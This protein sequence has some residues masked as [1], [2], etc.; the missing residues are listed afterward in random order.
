MAKPQYDVVIAGG[1]LAG[2]LTARE[3]ASRSSVSVLVLEQDHEIGTPEHCGGLVSL[4]GLKKLG[5][6]PSYRS[7]RNAIARAEIRSKS[8]FFEIDAHR[9]GVIAVDRRELD[10]QI[11]FQA[12]N[13]GVEIRTMCSMRSVSAA[14]TFDGRV[15]HDENEGNRG[16]A[17]AVKTTEGSVYCKFFVDATGLSSLIR[18]QR[19]GIL[20]SG[21]Y[22]VYAPWVDSDTV[23]LHFD[24]DRYPGFFAWIIPLG[25]NKAKIGVAGSGINVINTLNSF[26]ESKGASYSIIR[27]VYAPIYVAGPIKHF[28]QGSKFLFVGDAAGQT[29]PTTA[30][31]IL[32]SGMGGLL[33]GRA[34][35]NAIETEDDSSLSQY[36]VEWLSLF[37]SEFRKLLLARRVFERLDNRALDE[38]FSTVSKTALRRISQEGDFDFHSAPLSVI[39]DAKSAAR[40]LRSLL[41][42]ELRKAR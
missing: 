17:F 3:L 16:H 28:I 22:E 13:L 15:K 35:S 7:Y 2:L 20:P 34:V 19:N 24:S 4:S 5:I 23:E 31:G 32:S 11:A 8:S 30:G 21:Q 33:A 29:K 41:G 14:H 40:M 9:Q 18:R 36:H 10:K 1:S 42:N 27:K 25:E 6:V 39:F 38:I 26:L 37:G 12:Q